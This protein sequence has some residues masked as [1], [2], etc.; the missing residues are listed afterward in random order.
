[1]AVLR[2]GLV[3]CLFLGA[4]DFGIDTTGLAGEGGFVPETGS[5]A[6]PPDDAG[7]EPTPPDDT[8][9]PDETGTPYLFGDMNVE[10]AQDDVS[11]DDPDGFRYAA[12]AGG[13]A[14]TVWV[15]VDS[16]TNNTTSFDVGIYDDDATSTPQKP[17]GLLAYATFT[18]PSSGWVSQTLN[19]SI[20]ITEDSF[21]W[22]VVHPTNGALYYRNVGGGG[23]TLENVSA[24]SA[25]LPATWSSVNN[26]TDGP[27]SMYVTP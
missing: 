17:K 3:C 22:I 20:T 13:T 15:Y 4:C 14:Q 5:D 1:M 2:F 10:S 6:T 27:A 7:D 18:A 21:Y 26:A 16:Q 8:G 25:T 19:Q 11:A 12:I 24:N 23:G 9:P